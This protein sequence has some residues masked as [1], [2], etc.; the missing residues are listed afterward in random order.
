MLMD[1]G[2]RVGN[3]IDGHDLSDYDMVVEADV[4]NTFYFFCIF[5]FL[6]LSLRL[7]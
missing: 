6:D 2:T 5:A 7:I 3:V 4:V 1:A